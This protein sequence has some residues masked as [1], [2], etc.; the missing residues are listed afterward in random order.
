[1]HNSNDSVTNQQWLI[2]NYPDL[3]TKF[4]T[5]QHKLALCDGIP[6]ICNPTPWACVCE[7]CDWSK[8]NTPGNYTIG[9]HR[10]RITWL[11]S[12]REEDSV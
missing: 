12:A 1:M 9:C 6:T 2:A 5:A 7:D 4:F 11:S 3:V 8:F 10:A